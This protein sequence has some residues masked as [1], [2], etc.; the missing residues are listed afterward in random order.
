MMSQSGNAVGQMTIEIGKQ[1]FTGFFG[2]QFDADKLRALTHTERVE[3]LRFRFG[4]VFLN[5]FKG[6]VGLDSGDCF[7]WL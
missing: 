3:W 7:V 5:P 1:T 2:S 6:L 4:L